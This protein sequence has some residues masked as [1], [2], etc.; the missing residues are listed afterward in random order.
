MGKGDGAAAGKPEGEPK[1][2]V[3]AAEARRGLG[4]GV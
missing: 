1:E 4:E 3:E 2:G